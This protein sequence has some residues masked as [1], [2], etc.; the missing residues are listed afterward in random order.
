[1]DKL[2]KYQCLLTDI[3]EKHANR[4]QLADGDGIESYRLFDKQNAQYMLYRSGWWDKKRIRTPYLYV[5]I[6]NDKLWIEEDYTEDGL[7]T[8][9]LASGVPHDD[10][11]LGFRHP[12]IRSDTEFAV[13]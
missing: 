13:A 10:I 7:A 5:H 8:D 3:M 12:S 9:L 2:N 11:V 4:L 6:K 1:M